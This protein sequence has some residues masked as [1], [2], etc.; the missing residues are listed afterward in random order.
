M[1]DVS[2]RAHVLGIGVEFE[3]LGA[4]SVKFLP[5][6][7]AVFGQGQTGVTYTT[8]KETVLRPSDVGAKYG[9]KS[10]LYHALKQL[11][12]DNGDGIGSIAVT[13]F[14]LEDDASGVAA[15]GDITPTGA[16]TEAGSYRL[17][18]GGVPGRHF[19]IPKDATISEVLGRAGDSIAAVLEWPMTHTYT[20]GS[21]TSTPDA[22]NTGDGTVGSLSV[23]GAPRP[24]AYNLE[25]TA[26]AVDAGTFKL[27]DPNGTVLKSDI[28]VGVAQSVNGLDFT[29]SDGA[30]DFAVGD[31]F[32]VEVPATDM[33]LTAGWKGATGNEVKLSIEGPSNGITF[34]I[35]QPNGGLVNPDIASAISKMGTSVW[36][37]NC[38]NCLGTEDSDALDKL[39][40]AGD[41]R[42]GELVHK[43]FMAFAGTTTPSV[44]DAV[45]V[46]EGRKLDRIN[47]QLVAPGSPDMPFV[48]GA[49]ELARIVKVAN[50]RPSNN[51][52]G[53]KV[54]NLT[55]GLDSEQWDAIA[56]EYAVTRGSSTVEVNDGVIELGDVVTYYHPTGELDPP[57]RF[58]KTI[59]KL[60]TIIYNMNL[61]FAAEAWKSAPL[62]PDADAV[63][64]ETAKQPKMAV[65]DIAGLIDSLADAAIIVDR[66]FAK[67]SIKANIS[68]QNP[69]RLDVE[70][71]VK[72]SGNTSI[73]DATLK[74]GFYLGAG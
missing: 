40:T 37:T 48:V 15:V 64:E 22:G 70:V 12:P 65:A 34:A 66:A 14:P 6:H 25:C 49:R 26:V 4:G 51:Y 69:D 61:L 73:I 27:V 68:D 3:D 21:P 44:Q 52:I 38:L 41:G 53:Q 1:V 24:G 55:P 54:A 28:T 5:Q 13:V 57:Y 33:Q 32:A 9:Y 29:I 42:W 74:F 10:P 36:Y 31:K 11:R 59:T 7:V 23:T 71:T 43:P 58:A 39:Q 17:V 47:G 8:T 16:Q 63:L 72:V 35:T 2:A 62:V 18:G 60:Q 50:N 67:K 20:Y 56:R 19:V 45:V 46:P 30:A